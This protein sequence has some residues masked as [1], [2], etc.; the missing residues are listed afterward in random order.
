MCTELEVFMATLTRVTS[1]D[2]TETLVVNIRHTCFA[3][4]V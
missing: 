3:P 4:H 2:V 1:Y